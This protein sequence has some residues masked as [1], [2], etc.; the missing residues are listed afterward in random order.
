MT[1]L[2]IDDTPKQVLFIKQSHCKLPK[3]QQAGDN[4]AVQDTGYE[5]M[6]VTLCI[7]TLS[8]AYQNCFHVV[9]FF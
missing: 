5:C 9:I 6:N 2:F 3:R 1:E 4:G 8:I 7:Y